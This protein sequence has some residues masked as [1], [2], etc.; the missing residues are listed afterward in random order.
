MVAILVAAAFGDANATTSP[1]PRHNPNLKFFGLWSTGTGNKPDDG[2]S[3]QSVNFFFDV[4]DTASFPA[5]TAR[6]FGPSLL[7]VRTVL[8]WPR[9]DKRKGLR[10]DFA[11]RWN[12]TLAKLAP[13]LANGSSMGVFLG[14]ELCWNCVSHAELGK[15]ADLVRATMPPLP[16]QSITAL[17]LTRPVIYYNEAFPTL[18][19]VGMWN[20]TCG[21]A[22]ALEGSGGGYPSVPAS[23]D[24]VSIDYYP[25]EGT[26]AG[27]QRIYRER[28]FPRMQAHQRVLF[29]PPAFS[30]S[31]GSSA[32]FASRAC[33][34]NATRDGANPPCGGDCEAAQAGWARAA[35]DWART[36]ARFV[37]LNPWFWE[38]P[39]APS[40]SAWPPNQADVPGLR[41]MTRVL[42]PLYEQMGREIVSGRQADV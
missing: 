6:G 33:C 5:L 27:A 12:A 35:Y 28:L 36:E 23:I 20:A 8:F 31:P 32:A 26:F 3:A 41:W 10:P 1:Q 4:N 30:C 29:V 37:G 2:I 13:L 17:G 22:V 39:G 9:H 16:S 18:D 24:W 21:P 7:N 14:D 34:N 11:V 25:N 42:R 19:D 15:A 38:Q 40:P